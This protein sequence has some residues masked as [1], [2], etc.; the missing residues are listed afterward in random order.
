MEKIEIYIYFLNYSR[1]IIGIMIDSICRVYFFF[2][3]EEVEKLDIQ[4]KKAF[5]AFTFYASIHCTH[6]LCK[7]TSHVY[8]HYIQDVN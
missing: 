2:F 5:I 8:I 7:Y 1:Q 4:V 3:S 6:L